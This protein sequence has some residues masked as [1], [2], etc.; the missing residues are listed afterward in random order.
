MQLL[1]ILIL[2]LLVVGCGQKRPVPNLPSVFADVETPAV[3][4]VA[5]ADAADDPAIWYNRHAP[6]RSII[7]GTVKR[8]GLEVYDL[9]GKR[10]HRYAIGN[11][12]N[13]DVRYDFPLANGELVDI[14][15]CTDRSNNEI[16][17]F[18]INPSDG[19]L[20]LISGGR[21]RSKAAEVYGICMYKNLKTN[22]FYVFL[23]S[24]DGVIEQFR[25]SPFGSDQ[26]G[27]ELLRTFK[28]QTQPEGMVS[29]DALGIVYLGEEDRGVWKFCPDDLSDTPQLNLLENSG[30][31]NPNITYDIEGM[32][33]YE[34][35]DTSGYLLVSSQ[36]NNSYAVFDRQGDNRYFGSFKIGDG[37]IDGT[38]DTDG[39][40]IC[41]KNLGGIFS[42]GL[43]VAQ[44]GANTSA[45]GKA[46]AQNFKL[47]AWDK[48][49]LILPRKP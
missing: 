27:G 2:A 14:A 1:Q 20:S 42:K 41:S 22:D 11:P 12:N 49:E 10:L 25:L 13:A 31:S 8:F 18:R 33:I 45:L 44:D 47:V 28:V 3:N 15:A 24:K 48:I 7:I 29:D 43:L 6:E 17:I 38:Y 4:A 37:A 19:S 21:L 16:L 36:G 5:G 9:Q 32:A 23:N 34:A 35:S 40:E 39:I 30:Q 26:I 46:E